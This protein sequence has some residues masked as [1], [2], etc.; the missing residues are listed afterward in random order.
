MKLT[1]KKLISLSTL[2]LIFALVLSSAILSFGIA[3]P[4]N[5]N[6]YTADNVPVSLGSLTL[7]EYEK[8]D[9]GGVIDGIVL[10]KLYSTILGTT[11]GTYEDVLKEVQNSTSTTIGS[12][13]NASLNNN[14]QEHSI[15]FS[16]IAGGSPITVEFGGYKWNVV[17][18]TTNT[19][20]NASNGGE[21]GDLIAT[22][23]MAENDATVGNKQWSFGVASSTATSGLYAASEYGPS[24]IRIETL[25]GGSIDNTN[26]QYATSTSATATVQ[27]S[28]RV[29]N[30]YAKFTMSNSALVGTS[31]SNSS[32]INFL[33]TPAQVNYQIAENW[34]WSY[35]GIGTPY[36]CPNEAWGDGS[37]GVTG[38]NTSLAYNGGQG[39]VGSGNTNN[40]NQ[41][42]THSR[43]YE[44]KNDY[45]WLP[46]LTETGFYGNNTD[47]GTS[48]WGIPNENAIL[49]S[50]GNAWLRSGTNTSAAHAHGLTAS[51]GRDYVLSS[52]AYAVRPALHLNLTKAN[53]NALR[54][55]DTPR[56]VSIEYA[57]KALK[58]DQDSFAN[59]TSEF[60]AWYDAD[61]MDL[62]Y[63]TADMIEVGNYNVTVT[64]KQELVDK[65][66]A[67]DGSFNA[68]NGES[69]ISRKIKFKITPRKL[70]PVISVEN[71]A[72]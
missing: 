35:N 53:E 29:S 67:F 69:A 19:N 32:L 54:L 65:D 24:K 26:T 57:G 37:N 52:T 62:T 36:L 72:P 20:A 66:G 34:V 45:L 70:S 31:A 38:P 60:P 50:S 5:S 7:S 63:E 2:M 68:A 10:D 39:W 21:A 44:W 3:N 8:R 40:M 11:A 4:L 51:G 9:D 30:P 58:I 41:I 48:L 59:S 22:L 55:Y 16:N 49:K 15:N 42:L 47:L 12:S 13:S 18:L 23:W 33:A 17:Y 46:S 56:D 1:K 28:A 25:N 64:L 6:A 14:V 43:Y 71:N 61:K 27:A